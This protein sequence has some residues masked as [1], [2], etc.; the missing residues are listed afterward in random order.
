MTT[1]STGTGSPET[2]PGDGLNAAASAFESLLAPA[3]DKPEDEEADAEATAQDEQAEATDE[4]TEESEDAEEATEEEGEE[5]ES[6][7]EEQEEAEPA[8]EVFTVK[9]DGKEVA[10]SKD[11]LIAGYS[12]TADYTRK[13]QQ[14]AEERKALQAEAESIRTQ[15]DEYAALLPKLKASLE[16][17]IGPEPDWNTLRQ[18]DPVRATLMWQ[19][20]EETKRHIAAVEAE[21]ARV[22]SQ[23]EAE[24]A[25]ELE[26]KITE[27]R[28]ALLQKLPQWRDQKV[29]RKESESISQMMAEAGFE[30]DEVQLTDHRYVLIALKAAKYDE[31]MKQ[32]P[33][34]KD[35][36]SKAPVVKPGGGVPKRSNPAK[37]AQSQLRK[38][39]SVRDAAAVFA[40]LL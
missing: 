14:V 27:E 9:V 10:V 37:Q 23:S 4:P 12:R 40:N 2:G 8:A 19:M 28:N 20:R 16:A 31:M 7:D 33:K 36:V 26:R 39:G 22:R 6:E 32:A 15:R 21:E 25:E 29:A 24:Q 5:S 13:T 38:S 35:K 1:N 3:E 34:L 17:G 18:Q 30:P 11:E